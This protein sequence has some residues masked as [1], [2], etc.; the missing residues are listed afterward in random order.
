MFQWIKLGDA[1]LGFM[2]AIKEADENIGFRKIV[3]YTTYV[4][5]V[6]GIFNWKSIVSSVLDYMNHV[7][8]ARHDKD[9]VVRENI[10]NEIHPYLVE[11][12]AKAS[13]DRVMLF[14]FH[15]SI[16]NLIGI[17]FKYITM[18]G[19]AEPY[20]RKSNVKYVDVN[21]ELIGNF[22]RDLKVDTYM[23][24]RNIDEFKELDSTVSTVLNNPEAR[25]AS[26]QYMSVMGKPLGILVMEWYNPDD[27]P[28]TD[29]E[30]RTIR[31]LCSQATQDLNH[32]I[33]KYKD[34]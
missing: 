32:I 33:L 28:M 17:P 30:W 20:G 9:L 34:K 21:A 29:R 5:V 8:V 3:M 6:V 16:S 23:E 11:L 25:S 2:K 1:L 18:T 4:I 22:I 10:S 15:N 31:G 19:H 7:E 14:E 13:A 26:Y 27:M 12:R 24:V